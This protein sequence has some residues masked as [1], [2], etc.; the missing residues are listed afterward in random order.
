MAFQ[1]PDYPHWI[2]ARKI[3]QFLQ[4]CD[5]NSHHYLSK[6]HIY[7][8]KIA[9]TILSYDNARVLNITR[10]MRDVLV[11][12]YYHLRRMKKVSSEFSDYYW[13][14]GRLKSCQIWDYHSVWSAAAPN[15]YVTSFER[16]KASFDDE[17]RKI[18]AFIGVDLSSEDIARIREE[19]SLRRLQEMRGETAKPEAERF[20]RKGAIGDWE[21]YFD[22][23]MLDDLE[24]LRTNGLGVGN[25]IKYKLIF[26]YRLRLK[27]YL[28][29]RAGVA[30]S[31]LDRW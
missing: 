28:L 29:G 12:H 6:S 15:L 17:V 27:N 4:E 5:Y 18:G 19:T 10:D 23:R 2:D 8:R 1:H 31:F 24:S 21:S 9:S 20:F 25:S 11:S 16:L 13:R 3:D 14:V 26:D 7:D 30:S 22:Q